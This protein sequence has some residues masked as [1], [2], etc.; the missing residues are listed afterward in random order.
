M[1]KSQSRVVVIVAILANV[2]VTI[3]KFAAGLWTG[4]S[5]MLSEGVHSLVDTG[6]EAL[7][8]YGQYRAAKPADDDHPLGHGRELDFWSFI[9]ALL[10]FVVGSGLSLYEGVT[11]IVHPEP[12]RYPLVNFGVIGAAFLLDGY[13]WTVA[14]K[15]FRQSKGKLGWLQAVHHSKDPPSFMVLF[16]D[17]ADLI[18]LA[19][20]FVG[21]LASVIWRSPVFDGVASVGVGALLGIVALLLAR[22]TKRLLIGE[23][24]DAELTEA[25]VATTLSD[26]AA[27]GARVIFSM[28]L[29]PNDVVLGLV[30]ELADD[31]D[32]NGISG[33]IKRLQDTITARHPAVNR[34]LISIEPG[35]R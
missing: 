14:V 32:R 17:S 33:T 1:A 34:V 3:T 30:I 8:L 31:V 5:A 25:I 16:E 2:L 21:N 24:A 35:R 6:N 15:S 19:F 9:V 23:Q 10:I 26:N 28:Q 29:A 22:E 4:S 7:L 18:G 13:S 20:A 27:I 12:I 11:Q